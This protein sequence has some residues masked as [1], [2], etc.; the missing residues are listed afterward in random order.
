MGRAR[1]IGRSSVIELPVN[2][3]MRDVIVTAGKEAVYNVLEAASGLPAERQARYL[4][5]SQWL[6]IS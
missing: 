1:L 4:Y 6:V 2:G 5:L 3:V